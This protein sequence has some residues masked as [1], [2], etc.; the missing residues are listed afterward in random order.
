MNVLMIKSGYDGC[1]YVRL[2]LP[3]WENGYEFD[4][5][6]LGS[7]P[8]VHQLSAKLDKADIVVFHRPELPQ[9]HRMAHVLKSQGKLIVA[10]NDDTFKL[11]QRHPLANL[12][13]DAIEM[14]IQERE[15][16]VNSFLQISDLVT[17]ST[18]VLAK[19]YSK[20]NPNVVILPNCIDP[21]DWDEPLRT[22]GKKVRI[23]LVGSASI[24]FD[25]LHIKKLIKKLSKRNDVQIVLFGLGDAKHR[26]NNPNVTKAFKDEYKFW[27]S[28]KNLEQFGWCANKYYPAR[29]NEARLDMML[30]PRKINYFNTCKSNIKFLEASMCEIPVVAQSFTNGPYEEIDHGSNGFLIEDNKEWEPVIERLIEE[31]SLRELIGATAKQ[32]VLKNHNI[33][34]HA[35]RWDEVYTKLYE[36][37]R[38]NK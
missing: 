16:N 31:K 20:I 21:F 14:K 6:K 23:G 2:E 24:E 38:N 30:I 29:L 27:D 37:R 8:N 10:D 11:D 3:G 18:E 12:L 32:Y 1:C 7:Q 22:E 34:D 15:R 36:K 35:Y 9:Y 4:N 19:E 28:I 33:E 25:Y 26:K 13:D 17:T 5:Y